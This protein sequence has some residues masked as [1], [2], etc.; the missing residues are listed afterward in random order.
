MAKSP[1]S[2]LFLS[3]AFLPSFTMF[4]AESVSQCSLERSQRRLERSRSAGATPRNVAFI[5]RVFLA[6]WTE[7]LHRLCS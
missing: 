6:T 2:P 5:E 7:L 3:Y 4:T 1:L